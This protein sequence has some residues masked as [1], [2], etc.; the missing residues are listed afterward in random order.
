MTGKKVLFQI[1]VVLFLTTSCGIPGNSTDQGEASLD[2]LKGQAAQ[3]DLSLGD[4]PDQFA[5]YDPKNGRMVGG[6]GLFEVQNEFSFRSEL[7]NPL[8]ITGMTTVYPYIQREYSGG[9]DR[10]RSQMELITRSITKGYTIGK[11]VEVEELYL[12]YPVGNT[13]S[14]RTFSESMANIGFPQYHT[15]TQI[16]VFER[17]RICVILL[18]QYVEELPQ[19]VSLEDVAHLL[20]Q[21]I[22]DLE[23]PGLNSEF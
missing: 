16:L 6:E 5:E 14:G 23:S 12:S 10:I 4:F 20:D 17:N 9:T 8:T 21:R 7:E 3:V 15:R 11:N 19:P 1:L 22:R 13:Y 2:A 18:V